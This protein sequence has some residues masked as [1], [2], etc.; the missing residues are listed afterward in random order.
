MMHRLKLAALAAFALFAAPAMAADGL[1]AAVD[2]LGGKTCADSALT[3]VDLTE[4]YD[5]GKPGSN[6]TLTV[7]FAVHFAEGESKG[8]L[9]YA[10]GGPGG[11]GTALADSYLSSFDER[12][13]KEM[14]VVFFDQ[15][16]TGASSAFS[17]DKAGSVFDNTTFALD[18]P[19]AAVAAAKRFAADCVAE[20]GHRDLLPFLGTD[21][22]IQ[23][24][25]DFRRRIGAPKV[26]FY[27]ESY[28]TQ[29][30]QTYATRYPDAIRGV[31]IDGVVDLTRDASAF[32]R[33]DVLTAEKV[34]ARVFTACDRDA[35]CHEDMGRPAAEVYDALAAKLAAKPIEVRFPRGDG[36]VETRPMTSALLETDAFYALYGPDSRVAFLRAL[37]AAAQDNLL[38][39]LRLGYSNLSADPETL[40]P[41]K[42][43]TWFGGAYYA[44][45]CPDYSDAGGGASQ[46]QAI[47]AE[48]KALAP[49]APRLIRDAYVE[50]LVCVFWP[51]PGTAARPAPFAGG[52]YPTLV[53]NSDADPATPIDNGYAVFDHAANATMVT[54]RNGPH[55]IWGRGLACPD[56]IVYALMLDGRRPEKREQLCRQD[57]ID[58]YVPLTGSEATDAFGIARGVAIEIAHSP[59]LSGW[60]GGDPL[61][62]GCDF[63]GTV[64]ATAA[65]SGTEYSFKHCAFW[66]GLTVDGDGVDIDGSGEDDQ[67]DGASD[68]ARPDGLTLTLSLAGSHNGKLVYRRDR[69]T[70]AASLSGTF[71]GKPVATPRP[72]P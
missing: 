62:V 31:V 65:E 56:K 24:V 42:D 10:V 38:P 6:Q 23:D 17:C 40:E 66:P 11:A 22:A 32:Y 54:M 26:W 58:P 69:T 52:D 30:A 9:F 18:A 48:A 8:I 15:R 14:D 3:C 27:G 67:D 50:R 28:G 64:T 68:A 16:G 36:G 45:T 46:I 61:S 70:E 37:A 35:R 34:L 13:S 44:I 21:Q 4:P 5:H 53:L 49:Q 43:P 7:R 1:K 63:G 29:F 39:L 33:D 71:D 51:T 20:G 47:L 41:V 12:L 19:D 55:V 57:L 72:L 2:A 59:E 25:E 60:D